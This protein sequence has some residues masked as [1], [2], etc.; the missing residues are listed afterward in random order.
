MKRFRDSRPAEEIIHRNTLNLLFNAQRGPSLGLPLSAS[1]SISPSS[2]SS[3]SPSDLSSTETDGEVANLDSDAQTAAAN[4]LISENERG[5][6]SLHRFWKRAAAVQT[7][8]VTTTID[9]DGDMDM[10]RVAGEVV[11][12]EQQYVEKMVWKGGVGWVKEMVAC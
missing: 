12:I 5:Q 1:R 4:G 3:P 8:R 11:V 6:S 10:D 2:V 9:G 7:V